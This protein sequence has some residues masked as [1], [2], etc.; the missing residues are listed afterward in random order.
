MYVPGID[1]RKINKVSSVN[2]DTAVLDLE[3]G[4]ALSKKVQC[5]CIG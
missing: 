2:V 4:V 1:Q 3:D 5:T